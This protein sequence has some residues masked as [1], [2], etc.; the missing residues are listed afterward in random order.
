MSAP[1]PAPNNAPA[2][3]STPARRGLKWEPLAAM[4]ALV[5]VCLWLVLGS[6]ATPTL[7]PGATAS[8]VQIGAFKGELETLPDPA[9][10]GGQTFRVLGRDGHASP[11]L[12]APE[13]ERILGQDGLIRAS[14]ASGN[15]LFRALNITGWTSLVWVCVGVLGQIAF[16]GRML[17]QWVISEKRRA[18]VV[19]P[20]FWWLSLVGAAMLLSYFVWR[21]DLVAA[22][23]QTPGVVIYARNLRLIGKQRRR[24]AR[25]DAAAVPAVA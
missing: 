20:I 2:P 7:R 1:A 6:T 17:V 23:G 11:L 21:Q 5:L 18:S 22:L 19:P 16:F 24:L 13:L 3:A 25:P 8:K 12:T 14:A 10:P 15:T 9:A 4:L